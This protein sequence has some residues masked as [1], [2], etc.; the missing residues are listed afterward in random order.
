MLIVRAGIQQA[1]IVLA[2]FEARRAAQENAV[3]RLSFLSPAIVMT[4]SLNTLAGTSTER[5]RDFSRQVE[6][7]QQGFE[8]Y[9]FDKAIREEKISLEEYAQFPRFQYQAATKTELDIVSLL[10]GLLT[11]FLLLSALIYYRRDAMQKI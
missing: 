3:A 8:R 10:L 7:F 5:Y 6:V 4:Q 2:R 9:F 1:N 11:P